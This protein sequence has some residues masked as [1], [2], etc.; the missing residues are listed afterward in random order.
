MHPDGRRIFVSFRDNAE[1]GYIFDAGAGKALGT[2]PIKDG[3]DFFVS[4]PDGMYSYRRLSEGDNITIIVYETETGKELNSFSIPEIPKTVRFLN[5]KINGAANY[6]GINRIT[7]YGRLSREYSP[8]YQPVPVYSRYDTGEKMEWPDVQEIDKAPWVVGVCKPDGTG[9]RLFGEV[10]NNYSL[11]GAV[12]ISPDGKLLAVG[13]SDENI[14]IAKH[15][16]KI[17]YVKSIWSNVVRRVSLSG[18]RFQDAFGEYGIDYQTITPFLGKIYIYDIETGKR[19]AVIQPTFRGKL[20]E[21]MTKVSGLQFSPDG[22]YLVASQ[23]D[24]EVIFSIQHE[25]GNVRFT[26][27]RHF[28]NFSY[29]YNL[30]VINFGPGLGSEKW[31]FNEATPSGGFNARFLRLDDIP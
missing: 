5:W 12:T 29:V 10:M 28:N 23:R 15:Q 19:L 31:F 8:P 11:I 2:F 14:S 18:A 26:E 22:N 16:E 13:T 20:T 27:V 21:S 7:F 4:T 1:D 30:H 17:D 6:A 9:M 25:N 3:K 24:N